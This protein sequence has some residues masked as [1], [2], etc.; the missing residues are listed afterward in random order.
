MFN[1]FSFGNNDKFLHAC[2]LV[3][4][5]D[6]PNYLLKPQKTN[7]NKKEQEPT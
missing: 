1:S 4:P 7:K 2:S 5:T 3:I 6:P